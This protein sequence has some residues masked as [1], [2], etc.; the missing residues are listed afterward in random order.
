MLV[1]D[2]TVL[3]Y[4]K[5]SL[6]RWSRDFKRLGCGSTGECW[7][8]VSNDNENSKS[9]KLIRAAKKLFLQSERFY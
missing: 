3:L 8:Y 7:D 4:D 2:R 1:S 9:E 6:R 5:Q